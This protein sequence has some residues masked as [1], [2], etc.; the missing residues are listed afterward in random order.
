VSTPKHVSTPFAQFLV[1]VD[2]VGPWWLWSACALDQLL[3]G[4]S[5]ALTFGASGSLLSSDFAPRT[6]QVAWTG[7]SPCRQPLL[8]RYLHLQAASAD[9]RG[10]VETASTSL[11]R[12][13][14]LYGSVR[15]VFIGEKKIMV[16]NQS[17]GKMRRF[18]LCGGRPR[19]NGS[20][21]EMLFVQRFM[22]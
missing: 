11:T 20:H 21:W 8:G 5:I 7:F 10:L 12:C 4:G 14:H 16:D 15:T 2:L 9:K 18:S 13:A 6:A 1:V 19:Q 17:G 22:T 3:P